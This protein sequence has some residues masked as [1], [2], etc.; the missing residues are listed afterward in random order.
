VNW[1]LSNS[2]EMERIRFPHNKLSKQKV[3]FTNF[4]PKFLMCQRWGLY[5]TTL[6]APT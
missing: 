2:F 3:D 6:Y 4:F 5:S 1:H